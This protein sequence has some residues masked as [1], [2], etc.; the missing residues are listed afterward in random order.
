M[1][2]KL[3][4][5]DLRN[6]RLPNQLL[7]LCMNVQIHRRLGHRRKYDRPHTPKCLLPSRRQKVV[8]GRSR[9]GCIAIFFYARGGTRRGGE[10]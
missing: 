10:S 5:L 9:E 3:H 7:R 1:F 4:G 2:T 6:G 8:L